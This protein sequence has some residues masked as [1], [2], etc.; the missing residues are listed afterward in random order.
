MIFQVKCK[1][2]HSE[3]QQHSRPIM[4]AQVVLQGMSPKIM[5]IPNALRKHLRQVSEW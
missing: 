5:Q 3:K 1:K 2:N 4:Q